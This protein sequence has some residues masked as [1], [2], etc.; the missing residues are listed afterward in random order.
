MHERLFEGEAQGNDL[1]GRG[2]VPRVTASL[3]RRFP[4]WAPEKCGLMAQGM[5]ARARRA[6]EHLRN[7]DDEMVGPYSDTVRRDVLSMM[8]QRP[9]ARQSVS[10]SYRRPTTRRPLRASRRV[11]ATRRRASSGTR[12]GPASARPDDP[13]PEPAPDR[14]VLTALRKAAP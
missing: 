9:P 7:G 14:R 4:G 6:D 8:R 3:A 11:R 12:A 2:I 13:E 5:V 10:V 1:S